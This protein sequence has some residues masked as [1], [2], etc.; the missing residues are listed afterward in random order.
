MNILTVA[1]AAGIAGGA[2][3]FFASWAKKEEELQKQMLESIT[4]IEKE[5]LKDNK[6]EQFDS[7]RGT[8]TQI[9]MIGRV[10]EN[11]GNMKL[12]VLWFNTVIQNNTYNDFQYADI[13]MSK[14]EYSNMGLQQGS[15]VR[16]LIDVNNSES[17]ILDKEII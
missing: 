17:K 14:D 2:I 9:G 4:D 5:K 12:K 13:K 11:N 6:I 15:F 3:S 7:A 8:W 16:I 1:I 10:V